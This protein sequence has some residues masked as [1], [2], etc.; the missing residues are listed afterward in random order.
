M[1]WFRINQE[2]PIY[3]GPEVYDQ[4]PDYSR[5]SQYG[6]YS[7][8]VQY[9][10]KGYDDY[11]ADYEEYPYDYYGNNY[12]DYYGPSYYDYNEAYGQD[13]GSYDGQQ[14]DNDESYT[15]QEYGNPGDYSQG[16]AYPDYQPPAFPAY[17]DYYAPDKAGGN[18]YNE[19]LDYGLEDDAYNEIDDSF[20]ED[21]KDKNNEY[22]DY[23]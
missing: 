19:A 3:D 6:D 4:Y 2:D 23:K 18:Y 13:Y 22:Y 7:G 10:G 14:Y 5:R 15:N 16:A 11:S 8:D 1:H 20:P 9:Y 21:V 12:G 17:G